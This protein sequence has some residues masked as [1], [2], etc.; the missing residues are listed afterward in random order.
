MT[1]LDKK[2][3]QVISNIDALTALL[4]SHRQAVEETTEEEAYNTLCDV[5]RKEFETLFNAMD[6]EYTG[7]QES[8]K[9][10]DQV[11]ED[12]FRTGVKK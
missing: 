9:R 7:E 12:Y 11:T 4:V 5:C 6:E 8:K 3:R 10:R 2:K 1:T